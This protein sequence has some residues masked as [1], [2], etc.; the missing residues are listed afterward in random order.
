MA[1]IEIGKI[2][3]RR[4]QENQ[5]GVPQ[6]DGGEFAWAA[7]TERLYIGLRRADGGSRDD[8]VEILTENH[9]KNFFQVSYTSST[10]VY[11]EGSYITAPLDDPFNEP[12]RTIQE[13]LDEIEVSVKDFGVIGNDTD[14]G[15]LQW[16]MARLQLAIDRLFLD[17][18]VL[19]TSSFHP[20]RKLKFPAGIYNFTSTL[21]VPAYTT[22]VGEGIGKTIF[23][24]TTSTTSTNSLIKTIDLS[25]TGNGL[26]SGYKHFDY[27][28]GSGSE[29]SST[30]SARFI[31]IQDLTMKFDS[32]G[33]TITNDMSLLSLDCAD[34]SLIKRVEFIGNYQPYT[35][36]TSTSG[37]VAIN[38]RGKISNGTHKDTKIEECIFSNLH[39]GI[40]SNH[41]IKNIKISDNKFENLTRGVNFNDNFSGLLGP[42]HVIIEK[43]RFDYIEKQGIFVGANNNATTSSFI[44]SKENTYERVGYV[45]EWGDLGQTGTTAII[46]FLQDECASVDDKFRRAE[47]HRNNI[48]NVNVFYPELVEG[49]ALIES[50]HVATA[51]WP[52]SSGIIIPVLR[53]PFNNR[54]QHLKIK[55]EY[56][57]EVVGYTSTQVTSNV[58]NVFTATVAWSSGSVFQGYVTPIPGKITAGT[59]ISNRLGATSQ[60]VFSKL[61]T[62]EVGDIIES[63][64][65]IER[66]G[67][68][69]V[70][71]HKDQYESNGSVVDNYSYVSHDP[72]V[73]WTV[74][75]NTSGTYYT[76]QG[77]SAVPG[78]S[79]LAG[80]PTPTFSYSYSLKK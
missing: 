7:D 46:T 39:S 11:R 52:W 12:Q 5:T 54:N 59:R 6:L 66:I 74:D 15:V 41:D 37:Y 62:L 30:G 57:R 34:N 4:G 79:I 44:V 65:G 43:N 17:T 78:N 42:Q 26:A 45:G 23:N 56:L 58:T 2:Q 14:S 18:Q 32:S 77:K 29:F 73:E 76:L 53:M 71:V 1:V 38:L 51:S 63:A 48:N 50:N 60:L 31:T 28:S 47:I 27:G 49:Y 10:Y 61:V 16:D 80:T 25:S 55:Y 22:I 70:Y 9:L 72:Y 36:S 75:V 40:R 19:S 69:D 24:L 21:Y 68:L 13:K 33:T 3:V 67:E 35:G 64:Q 8:N 20:R